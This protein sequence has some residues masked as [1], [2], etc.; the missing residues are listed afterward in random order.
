MVLLLNE[1]DRAYEVQ[2]DVSVPVATLDLNPTAGLILRCLARVGL[3][4][5]SGP[6]APNQEEQSFGSYQVIDYVT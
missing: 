2:I 6:T 1:L 5:R 4:L 3:E